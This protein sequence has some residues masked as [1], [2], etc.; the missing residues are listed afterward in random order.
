MLATGSATSPIEIADTAT[1]ATSPVLQNDAPSSQ[2]M[3]MLSH[4]VAAKRGNERT[5]KPRATTSTGTVV[6]TQLATAVIVSRTCDVALARSSYTPDDA[7]EVRRL[8]RDEESSNRP[9]R[10]DL[11]RPS[12]SAQLVE[13]DDAV[14]HET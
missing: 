10:F 12:A 8:E 9:E 1:P 5:M 2:R 3:H 14:H 6:R 4:P 13:D 7:D 11:L